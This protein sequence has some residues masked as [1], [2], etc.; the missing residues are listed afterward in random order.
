MP[1]LFLLKAH[2]L[3]RSFIQQ[4]SVECSVSGSVLGM[5]YPK[6]NQKQSL[7]FGHHREAV[8]KGGTHFYSVH[9]FPSLTSQK[10]DIKNSL[11]SFSFSSKSSCNGSWNQSTGS[12]VFPQFCEL[13]LWNTDLSGGGSFM[14]TRRRL[15]RLGLR[16]PF[17]TQVPIGF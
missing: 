12:M 5:V 14:V 16:T 8:G 15:S 6:R 2:S 17:H 4:M 1:I 9:A 3:N 13:W 10:R 11:H 7:C